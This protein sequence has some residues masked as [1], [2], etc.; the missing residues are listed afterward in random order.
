[1]GL[2]KRN[3][4]V[5][6]AAI[7]EEAWV[8]AAVPPSPGGCDS[9]VLGTGVHLLVFFV[10]FVG[11]KPFQIVAMAI[12]TP[13]ITCVVVLYIWCAETNPGDPGIFDSTKN[14]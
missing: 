3:A 1:M 11:T 14:L 7:H 9:R 2:R 4:M 5:G 12:Y 13:L 6:E 8:A 10:P